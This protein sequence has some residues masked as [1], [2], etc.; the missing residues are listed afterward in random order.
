M[1]RLSTIF[2]KDVKILNMYFNKWVQHVIFFVRDWDDIMK[3]KFVGK[4]WLLSSERN[5]DTLLIKDV[6]TY[7]N[8]PASKWG[9]CGK[10]K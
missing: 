4:F 5:V 9:K 3:I 8:F 7:F 2:I 1:L 10:Y 6:M